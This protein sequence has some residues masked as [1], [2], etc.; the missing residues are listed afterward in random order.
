MSTDEHDRFANLPPRPDPQTGEPFPPQG[1]S[2]LGSDT[3]PEDDP[4]RETRLAH[5]PEP[6]E[7][8]G[9]VLAWHKEN[10]RGKA[11]LFLT[12]VGIFV[13]G[14]TILS[15]LRGDGGFDWAQFWFIWLGILGVSFLITRPFSYWV[16]SAGADW[17][18]IQ[19]I[20]WGA[21]RGNYVKLYELAKI[22]AYYGGGNIFLT[23]WDGE[24][25]TEQSFHDLQQDRR[26][27]DLIYNGILHSVAAGAEV[28]RRAW[29]ILSLN[30]VRGL[31]FPAGEKEVDIASMSDQQVREIMDYETTREFLDILNFPRDATP[32]QFRT[33]FPKLTEEF[34]P[35]SIRS[36]PSPG[37]SDQ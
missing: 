2:F 18:Q 29:G 7:G 8:M 30:E 17:L 5:R 35:P 4:D 10:L 31:R 3:K 9:P 13:V 6:P 32:D 33:K 24:R 28:S 12:T 36:T 27:W 14:L 37:T 25:G 26:I 15:L 23:L 19:R 1:R 11:G 34:L 16:T 21:T 22:D 20:R